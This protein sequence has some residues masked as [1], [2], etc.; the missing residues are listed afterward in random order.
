DDAARSG[1]PA[2]GDPGRGYSELWAGAGDP[3]HVLPA[4]GGHDSDRRFL[5]SMAPGQRLDSGVDL[6]AWYRTRAIRVGGIMSRVLITGA[7][8]YI[9]RLLGERLAAGHTVLGLDVRV[10]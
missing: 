6:V 7:G 8:G 5:G 10:P 1:R 3:V 2:G 9:G 4:G